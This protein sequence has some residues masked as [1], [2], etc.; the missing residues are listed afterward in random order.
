MHRFDTK[1]LVMKVKVDLL[2]SIKILVKHNQFDRKAR[3]IC[4]LYRWTEVIC[5]S[6]YVF[7]RVFD[8]WQ[9]LKKQS[10]SI[11]RNACVACET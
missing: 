11:P 8:V 6:I 2:M 3:L 1:Q 9:L 5:N 10:G 7:K 4:T